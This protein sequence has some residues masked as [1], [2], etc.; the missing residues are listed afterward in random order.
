MRIT[1]LN[2][3]ELALDGK[4]LSWSFNRGSLSLKPDASHSATLPLASMLCLS[5]HLG[6]LSGAE[7][8][9]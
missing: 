6:L 9:A 2:V 4:W 3:G 8:S 5:P 1:R 7:L